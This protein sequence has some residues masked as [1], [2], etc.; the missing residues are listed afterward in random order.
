MGTE[1]SPNNI[2]SLQKQIGIKIRSIRESKG[3]K[4]YEKFAIQIGF[5]RSYYWNIEKGEAN[6]TIKS[7]LK[8]LNAL[9]VTI[10]DFFKELKNS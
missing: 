1:N 3:I 4:N 10:E 6:L 8:I 5:S 7:L 2:E 9:G